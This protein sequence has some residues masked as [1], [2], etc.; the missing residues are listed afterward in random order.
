MIAIGGMQDAEN[1]SDTVESEQSNLLTE[2][3]ECYLVGGSVRDQKLGLENFDRDWVV[4]GASEDEMLRRG[5]KRVGLSFPVFLHPHTK[6]EYALARTERKSGRGYKGF[7][8]DVSCS[9]TLE[10]DLKRRDLTINA[11][12]MTPD[13]SRLI[14]PF[15][16]ERDLEQKVLRHVSEHFAEDPLR[17]LRVARFSARFH[18]KGFRLA[19]ETRQMM[20][21]IATRGE[22]DDLVPERVWREVQTALEGDDPWIF[23]QTLQNCDALEKLFPEL[24][25][26]FQVR[27]A[28]HGAR[29]SEFNERAETALSNV[30]TDS[31]SAVR[32]SV[33]MYLVG[34]YEL[35][36]VKKF[37]DR[38]KVPVKYS[39]LAVQASKFGKRALAMSRMSPE[40]M[41]DFVREL[42]GIR[43][44]KRLDDCVA[45]W[46]A[47]SLPDS[48]N[49]S[50]LPTYRN[51]MAS[52]DA[53]MLV[54]Y[55]KGEA[56]KNRI[57]EIQIEN[58]A[59]LMKEYVMAGIR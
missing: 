29:S 33:L 35:P 31:D 54:S 47:V 4:I 34:E 39:K 25:V 44:P 6:E 15:C 14:D 45:V 52:V 43:N 57:R 16:G 41:V 23:F 53:K 32:F 21:A 13:G 17:V 2:G 40:T 9:V 5:F 27:D 22:L 55:L 3:L 38:W 1:T 26:L 19:E 58:V 10:Q 8:V 18:S 24:L 49:V 12:A 42:D 28:V 50:L 7:E 36:A 46:E 20:T 51:A 37:C 48:S 30:A 59:S 11:M 56:L